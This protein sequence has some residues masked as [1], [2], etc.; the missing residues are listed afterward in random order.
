MSV[1]GIEKFSL[2]SHLSRVLRIRVIVASVSEFS[3][4]SGQLH[5]SYAEHQGHW[6][7]YER[8]IVPFRGYDS[9]AQRKWQIKID[10]KSK[11]ENE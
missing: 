7:R 1:A 8:R 4:L 3:V 6:P 11:Q 10:V 9:S 2:T 5:E